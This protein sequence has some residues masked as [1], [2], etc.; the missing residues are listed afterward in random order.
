MKL[1]GRSDDTDEGI[2]RRFWEYETHVV[3]AMK[4]LEAK[5]C[6]LHT[7]NGEQSIEGVFEEIKNALKL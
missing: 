1:R 6:M 5:G 7:V 4:A 3:P 2:N